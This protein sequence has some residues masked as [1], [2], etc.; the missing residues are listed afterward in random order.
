MKQT[1]ATLVAIVV[2]SCLAQPAAAGII[3]ASA[4]DPAIPDLVYDPATG[5]VTLDGTESGPFIGYTLQNATNSFIPGNFTPLLVGVSTVLTSELAEAALAP[6]SGSIGNVF[7]TGLDLAG[8]QALLTVNT[9]SV[10]LGAPLVP[11][12]LVVLS[13]TTTGGTAP[14][15]EPS[16]FLLTGL[17]M[18]GLGLYSWRRRRAAA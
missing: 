11:F 1:L 18:V 10:A 12:D 6:G 14:I 17:G 15:P 4:G 13:T 2:I 7:P 9:V 8:L 5:N 16:T 3:P